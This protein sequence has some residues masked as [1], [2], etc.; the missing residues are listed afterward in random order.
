MFQVDASQQEKEQI[1][2]KIEI[3]TN[4]YNKEVDKVK[5][6]ML[7]ILDKWK[8]VKEARRVSGM[9][10]VPWRLNVKQYEVEGYKS[11]DFGMTPM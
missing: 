4:L 7:A 9:E 3:A 5:A 6:I 1:E 8:Q 2:N 11:F 10:T